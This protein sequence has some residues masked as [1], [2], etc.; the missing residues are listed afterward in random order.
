MLLGF[1]I[2][3]PLPLTRVISSP[4]STTTSFS[5]GKV[6]GEALMQQQ[7]ATK[8]NYKSY[9]LLFDFFSSDWTNIDLDDQIHD[10]GAKIL[11]QTNTFIHSLLS[12]FAV[13]FFIFFFCNLNESLREP[14]K[15][16]PPVFNFSFFCNTSKIKIKLRGK[17]PH[18]W[19]FFNFIKS[20]LHFG[21]VSFWETW[22]RAELCWL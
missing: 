3:L 21:G 16:S 18:G 19:F 17:F 11:K 7:T 8:L 2:F 6:K 1:R 20:V 4:C 22:P 15:S 5:P 14:R 12:F 13:S 9:F 10:K